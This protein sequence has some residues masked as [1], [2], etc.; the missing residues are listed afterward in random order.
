MT[1][2]ERARW[3]AGLRERHV[4]GPITLREECG[5]CYDGWPCEVRLLLDELDAREKEWALSLKHL[6]E[7]AVRLGVSFRALGGK[8]E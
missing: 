4:R 5:S 8:D 1:P 7:D 2:E 3:L 6:A